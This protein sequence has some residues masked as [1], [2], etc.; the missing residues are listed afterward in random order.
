MF[1]SRDLAESWRELVGG[2]NSL[3]QTPTLSISPLR[4]PSRIEGLAITREFVWS[5]DQARTGGGTHS[6][7][8]NHRSWFPFPMPITNAICLSSLNRR[9]RQVRFAN[10]NGNGNRNRQCS[11]APPA[12][13]KNMAD[14]TGKT[15]M[16][17]TSRIMSNS[18]R[19]DEPLTRGLSDEL[20]P[21]IANNFCPKTHR[22]PGLLVAHAVDCPTK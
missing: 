15:A 21:R 3:L 19:Y 16:V 8:N 4:H 20:P 10:T 1:R 13:R 6:V 14:G 11:L 7:Y 9:A 12:P 5:P 2:T 22:C 17:G 18:D